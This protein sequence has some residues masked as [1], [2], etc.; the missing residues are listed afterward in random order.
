MT[1]YNWI[2]N[3]PRSPA[4][5]K[6]WEHDHGD[7]NKKI[8]DKACNHCGGLADDLPMTVALCSKGEVV[9]WHK[10]DYASSNYLCPNT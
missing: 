4:E 1:K 2:E 8:F 10:Y 9:W 5:L 3:F 7:V 6:L